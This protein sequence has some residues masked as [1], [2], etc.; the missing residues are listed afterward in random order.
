MRAVPLLRSSAGSRRCGQASQ[1][2]SCWPGPLPAPSASAAHRFPACLPPAPLPPRPRRIFIGLPDRSARQSILEVV[3]EGESPAADLDLSRLAELTEGY[4]GSDLKQLCVQAAMRPVRAFLEQDS[5]TA[6]AAEAAAAAA[7]EEAAARAASAAAGAAE[8]SQTEGGAG[9]G[10]PPGGLPAVPE[11]DG[12]TAVPAAAP[13]GL[14]LVPRLDSLL[15]QAERIASRPTNPRTDLRPI[16]MR[17]S[18]LRCVLRLA[19]WGTAGLWWPACNCGRW[20]GTLICILQRDPRLLSQS[21][22][23][24]CTLAAGL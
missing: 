9:E 24:I 21:V 20:D 18:G 17:V 6:A 5:A 19:A 3:L 13:I 8:E 11:G 2:T 22:P 10:G 1:R 12:D 15:R 16:S 4:S 7:Q 23:S 14:P